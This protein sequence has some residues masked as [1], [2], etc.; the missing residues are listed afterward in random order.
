MF[1]LMTML[2]GVA[3]TMVVTGIATVVFPEQAAGSL[4]E[5]EDG[6]VG[7]RLI[8]QSFTSVDSFQ[9]RP[10]AVDYDASGSGAS[11]LGP[12]NPKLI[13]AVTGRVAYYRTLNGLDASTPVPIDAVTSSASGLDPHISVANARLQASRVARERGLPL[14]TVMELVDRHT[15]NPDLGFLSEP[16][17]DVLALN[18]DLD[19]LG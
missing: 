6:V 5:S 17:V 11:N 9:P 1:L 13:E 14:T 15:V 2:T 16:A 18:L 19:S 4:V 12:T 8:G 7:S 3:Y 10:S